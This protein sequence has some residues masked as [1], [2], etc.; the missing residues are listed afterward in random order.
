MCMSL[1]LDSKDWYSL[2]KCSQSPKGSAGSDIYMLW[3]WLL[4]QELADPQWET[5]LFGPP[6]SDS[7]TP[8]RLMVHQLQNAAL[9]QPFVIGPIVYPDLHVYFVC[10]CDDSFCNMVTLQHHDVR[11]SVLHSTIHKDKSNQM[12]Q[13]SKFYYSIFIWSSTCFGRHAAHHQEPKTALAASGFSYV[14]GCW[15]LSGTLCLTT[16][17]N[18]TSNNL[19]RMTL[20]LTMSTNYT[21]NNLPRMQNQTLL[22]QF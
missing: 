18:Y 8:K 10:S 9:A 6:G 11:G 16:S 4:V 15:T 2:R 13:L 3:L 1:L 19:P 5:D 21:S 7:L 22:V 12:Q 14:E 20:C 17:T